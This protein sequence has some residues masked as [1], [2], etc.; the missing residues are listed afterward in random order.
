VLTITNNNRKT[1][2]TVQQFLDIPIIVNE[3]YMLPDR[4]GS[5]MSDVCERHF[6]HPRHVLSGSR[7]AKVV[8]AR[9]EF[10]AILHFRY[11]YLP[12]E[13]AALLN[14]DRTSVNHHLGMRRASKVKYD[15]LKSLYR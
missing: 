9:R 2:M 13:I 11:R 6:V 10:I 12:K 3:A 15:H 1:P 7:E 8:D 14:M 5:V 4:L